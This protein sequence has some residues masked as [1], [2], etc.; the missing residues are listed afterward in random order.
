[1]WNFPEGYCK[2]NSMSTRFITACIAIAPVKASGDELVSPKTSV[3]LTGTVPV[4]LP[5]VL[6]S[7]EQAVTS[8]ESV[9]PL[10]EMDP[11]LKPVSQT[12]FLQDSPAAV[13][14]HACVGIAAICLPVKS[15]S[16]LS[17]EK[18]AHRQTSDFNEV[19][20]LQWALEPAKEWCLQEQPG[21]EVLLSEDC[22][23][24]VPISE[25]SV[26]M[27]FCGGECAEDS[28][29]TLDRFNVDRNFTLVLQGSY[30]Q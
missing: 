5:V 22:E 9:A 26:L 27:N 13:P 4:V 29:N 16:T 12:T 14:S 11:S 19:G 23:G 10:Q 15:G 17:Q 2:K 6:D 21:P 25:M 8:Y 7:F 30:R 18:S 28:K 20:E 1:M 24:G 3:S